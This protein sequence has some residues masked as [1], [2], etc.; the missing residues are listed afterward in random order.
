MTF[1][2]DGSLDAPVEILHVFLLGILAQ[3][4]ASWEAFNISLL[5]ISSIQ[6]QYLVQHFSSLVGKEF[7]IILQTAPFFLYQFMNDSQK[8]LWISLGQ[9]SAYLFQTTIHN[10]SKSLAEL[11][12]HIFLYVSI[13]PHTRCVRVKILPATQDSYL[14]KTTLLHPI[15]DIF[16]H[17]LIKIL[18]QWHLPDSIARFGVSLLSTKHFESFNGVLRNASVHS[19]WH[20]TVRDLALSFLNYQAFHLVLSNAQLYNYKTHMAFHASNQVIEILWDNLLIQKSM[21]YN[22]LMIFQ[23]QLSDTSQTSFKLCLLNNVLFFMQ[24]SPRTPL[25]QE[26]IEH[27][28]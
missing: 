12:K 14:I 16:L 8:N 15:P 26:T 19:N 28:D 5:N 7:K 20:Q 1:L 6:L 2:L 23:L 13:T 17:H 22:Q 18:A 21:G 11:R 9:L 10:M 3:V 24:I 27:V 4:I 25:C